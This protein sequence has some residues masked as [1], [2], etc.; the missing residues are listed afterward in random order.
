MDL[1]EELLGLIESLHDAGTEYAVCG[2]IALAI[3][4]FPRFTK[5]IDLLVRVADLDRVR[6]AASQRGYSLEG[7]RM[8]FGAGTQTAREMLRLSK[9]E[10]SDLLTLDLLL[11][12]PALEDAW[13]SRWRIEWRGRQVSVV[14]R[15]GLVQMKRIS[16]RPQDLVDVDRMLGPSEGNR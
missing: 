6:T 15:D 5:D 10:G 1:V 4:G 16:G 11:V 12:S 14:S 9:A 8:S 3:H 13:K 2:G 7:G